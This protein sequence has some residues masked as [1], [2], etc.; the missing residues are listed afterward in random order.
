MA[1]DSVVIEPKFYQLGKDLAN[2]EKEVRD[3]AVETI[4]R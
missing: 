4:R 3:N 1:E 2:V